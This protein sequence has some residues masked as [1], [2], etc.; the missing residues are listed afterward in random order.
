MKKALV[1]VLLMTG[2]LLAATAQSRF[3]LL[4]KSPMDMSYYPVNYPILRIQDK[5]TEPPDCQAYLQQAP[6]KW[7]KRF[8]RAAGV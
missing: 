5:A 8:W 6:K 1:S 3:P 4:D 7:Q 2:C